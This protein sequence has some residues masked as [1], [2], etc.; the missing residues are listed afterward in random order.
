MKLSKEACEVVANSHITCMVD[1]KVCLG[2][3]PASAATMMELNRF[4]SEIQGPVEEC[5][6]AGAQALVDM[7]MGILPGN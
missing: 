1:L 7:A 2:V 4:F 5:A 6:S 3:V